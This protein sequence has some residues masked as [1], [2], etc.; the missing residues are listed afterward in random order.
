M[1]KYRKIRK[2]PSAP[3]LLDSHA[4]GMLYLVEVRMEDAKTREIT[5]QRLLV[6]GC[7]AA[8]IERKLRWI[9]EANRYSQFSIEAVEKVREKIHVLSTKITQPHEPTSNTI[10]R[11][12]GR[13]QEVVDPP[14][15]LDLPELIHYA[16]GITTRVYARDHYHALRKIAA[17]ISAQATDGVPDT[18]A[19]LSPDSTVQIEEI[20]KPARFAR[21]RDVSNI[22]ERA[23][24]VRG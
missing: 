4:L 24:F 7:E 5:K 20:A 15:V 13:Q 3:L 22:A 11:E 23:H 12:E 19:R 21:A 8:D 6:V 14:V 9:Y 17:A 10:L 2:A 16:V 18:T 1:A